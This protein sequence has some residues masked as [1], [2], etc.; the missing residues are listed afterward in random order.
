LHL[1][2]SDAPLR[3]LPDYLHTYRIHTLQHWNG[4]IKG[5]FAERVAK[6][7]AAALA[8]ASKGEPLPLQQINQIRAKVCGAY[9]SPKKGSCVRG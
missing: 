2:S 7:M 6:I 9:F 8:V 4:L 5:Y 3:L 1:T